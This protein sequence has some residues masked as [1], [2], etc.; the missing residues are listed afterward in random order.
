[1]KNRLFLVAMALIALF[2]SCTREIQNPAELPAARKLTVTMTTADTRTTVTPDPESGKYV[3]SWTAG[4]RIGVFVRCAGADVDVNVPTSELAE[5][6]ATA[7]FTAEVTAPDEDSNYEFYT[8]FPYSTLGNQDY[9]AVRV[10]VP[11][12]QHPA[13]GSF[14]PLADVLTGFPEEVAVEADATEVSG[15]LLKFARKTSIV[16]LLPSY[17]N[18]FYGITS[19]TY[20]T[21]V[22]VGFDQP[23]AGVAT[24]DLTADGDLVLE[25]VGA[26]SQVVLKYEPGT[27][28]ISD[29]L[30]LSIAPVSGVNAISFDFLVAE[31]VYLH[32]ETAIEGAGLSF[33][34]A[35]MKKFNLPVSDK[36]DL[37]YYKD[38]YEKVASEPADWS[39]EYLIVCEAVERIF[40]GSRDVLDNVSNYV[41]VTIVDDEITGDYSAYTFTVAPIDGGWSIRSASGYYIGRAANSNGLDASDSNALAN[42]I[43]FDGEAVVKSAAGHT[44]M[45]NATTGQER[46]R[47]FKTAAQT[48]VT[49]YKAVSVSAD[50]LPVFGSAEGLSEVASA[51]V[52]DGTFSV[53]VI[54]LGKNTVSVAEFDGEVVTAASVSFADG[55]AVVT[56]SVSANSGD[57]RNGSITLAA[58]ATTA[59]IEVP[60]E[61]G[62]AL[63]EISE[64]ADQN[65]GPEASDNNSFD[66]TILNA[67]NLE[68]GAE[69]DGTVVTSASIALK[70]GDVYTVTYSVSAN[71]DIEAREGSITVSCGSVSEVVK[72]IQAYDASKVKVFSRVTSLSDV[73]DGRYIIVAS[74]STLT[75]YLPAAATSATPKFVTTG[76][77][78]NANDEIVLTDDSGLAW[79]F[80]GTAD[81]FT[82]TDDDDDILYTI[83][84]NSGIRCGSTNGTWKVDDYP[85]VDGC[86]RFQSSNSNRYCGVYNNADWR[87]YTT[88]NHANYGNTGIKLYKFE[89]GR[90]DANL[91][92]TDA[93]ITT[94]G[95]VDVAM[96]FAS[97][98][99]GAI[100][101]STADGAM[102]DTMFSSAE[103]GDF[104]IT[105]SQAAT[106]V[107]R[108]ASAT[109]TVHVT[110]APSLEAPEFIGVTD[111][112]ERKIELLWSP[113]NN[114]ESY[115]VICNGTEYSA[116]NH[117]DYTFENLE[118]EVEYTISVRAEAAGYYSATSA[119][120]S[121]VLHDPAALV[122]DAPVIDADANGST[123]E[124]IWTDVPNATSYEVSCTGQE[125]IVCEPGEEYCEF[126]NLAAG[127]Y[128]VT[129]TAKADGYIDGVS[130]AVEVPVYL[131]F[132]M[133]AVTCTATTSSSLTFGW[134]AVDGA[135]NG[136]LV[137]TSNGDNT[138]WISTSS[139]S[140]TLT[141]LDADI[142]Y[143]LYVK[144]AA[145]GY[146]T[147]SAAASCTESTDAASE[148]PVVGDV[149]WAENWDDCAAGVTPSAYVFSGTTVYGDGTVSYAQSSTNTKTYAENLAGGDKPELLLSKSNQTWTIS[150]IPCEGVASATLT[151][152]ANR[153]TFALTSST[154]GVTISGSQKS[155]TISFGSNAPATFQIVLK[156]TGS[157]NARIDDV[158][159]TVASTK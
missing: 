116:S 28:K 106:D 55:S 31:N 107:Y 34:A 58:G 51:G 83:N 52:T 70:D 143:T 78:V 10:A 133:S 69:G 159:L 20:V 19:D 108:S 39:G 105:A 1:M 49:L 137:A 22:R 127:L 9:N 146:Y 93:N 35:S 132:T 63:P 46:F 44:L 145:S 80:S 119:A 24:W 123:I 62:I 94:I 26:S 149:L 139:T 103:P 48:A 113:V 67:G 86:F 117:P 114:A 99:D 23:V 3:P 71:E 12:E 138:E 60:Q 61:S 97:D 77:E 128:S 101:Y 11:A 32:G 88:Y 8:Y 158:E 85:D 68:L 53:P 153:T 66:V 56:Y 74:T 104:V 14:D 87:S 38:S 18:S 54:N 111:D 33:A 126:D 50:V 130:A 73:T 157:S 121:F 30:W 43:E 76:F 36:W 154:T 42:V 115:T 29:P 91:V 90:I 102:T 136:Y 82:I 147:E 89:D 112:K 72:I 109:A 37:K 98:S 118:Y 150:G 148:G 45:Y 16:R 84:N 95:Q 79:N 110:L 144:V 142:E 59:V 57:A 92:G 15:L 120:Q 65:V 4:D 131:P 7:S 151:F 13:N 124:V 152:K 40:D 5:A 41:D 96:L 2:A 141:G 17:D 156:N 27:H 21:E 122:L 129:V 100:T 47:Y 64:V 25:D 75:G 155:W 140:Y 125:S 134:T 6:S 135:D 81:A